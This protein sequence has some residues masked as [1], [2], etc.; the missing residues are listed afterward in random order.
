MNNPNC[1]GGVCK[2]AAGEV[3]VLPLGKDPNHGNLILCLGCFNHEM[4]WRRDRNR[5]L[6]KDC[7]FDILKWEDL[8]VYEG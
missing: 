6:G 4:F 5:E 7:K 3:R 2:S 8:K 1:D